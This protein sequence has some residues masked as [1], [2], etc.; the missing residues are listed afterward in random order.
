MKEVIERMM[1]VTLGFYW[2]ISAPTEIRSIYVA[3]SVTSG[4]LDGGKQC[5]VVN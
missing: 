3:A 5:I 1:G 2:E 4:R